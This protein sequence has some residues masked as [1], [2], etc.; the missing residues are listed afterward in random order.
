MMK[1]EIEFKFPSKISLQVVSIAHD[2]LQVQSKISEQGCNFY[3]V[4]TKYNPQSCKRE[5]VLIIIQS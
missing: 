3:L 1:E 4:N 2:T 5:S